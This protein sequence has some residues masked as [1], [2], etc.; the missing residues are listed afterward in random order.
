MNNKYPRVSIIMV[1][2][3]GGNVYRNCLNSLSKLDYPDWELILVDNGSTDGTADLSLNPKYGIKSWVIKN[4]HNVG[5]APANNQGYKLAKGKYL[6]LLN[7]D[8]LVEKNLLKIMV[9][10]MEKDKSIGAMQ[11]KIK[12]MDDPRYLDNAGSFMTKIGFLEHWGFQHRD[13]KEFDKEKEVFSV[14]GAC[15]FIRRAFV[16][17]YGLFDDDF[18]SYFEE[19]DFCWKVWLT[20]QRCVYY[21]MTFIRH[22][23]GMTSKRMNQI[24]INYH[25]V[26]NRICSLIK[27]LDTTNLIIILI[28]HLFINVLLTLYY[29]FCFQLAKSKMIALALYWNII[30]LNKTMRKRKLIQKSRVVKDKEIFAK[31]GRGVNLVQML[32]HFKKVEANFK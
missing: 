23:V 8:T 2:W 12:I 10:K 1:N 31:V 3:N 30:N 13:T 20:G 25:G 6:L 21:P 4:D 24:K 22:K 26:K 16:D 29:L 7:N 28:L 27:N 15:M 5:F 11:P 19:S 14:K 18:V 9:E 17:K 32:I